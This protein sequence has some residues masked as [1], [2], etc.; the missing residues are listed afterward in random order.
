MTLIDSYVQRLNDDMADAAMNRVLEHFE[1]I[2]FAWAGP[3]IAGRPHYYRIQG[4]RLLAEY[5][6]TTRDGNHVHTVWRDP[7]NDFGID[8]L[9]AHRSHSPH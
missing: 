7:V 3:T 4:P 1:Q 8:A 9:S 2:H 6:N 5:D